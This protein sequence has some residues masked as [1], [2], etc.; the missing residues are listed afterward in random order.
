MNR[1]IDL[2]VIDDSL[3]ELARI[4]R[5]LRSVPGVMYLIRERNEA[6][7][8]LEECLSDPPD[9]VLLNVYMPE[10]NGIEFL[11][12][13]SARREVNVPVILLGGFRDEAL[14][15]QAL[16]LG[17]QDYLQKD[18]VTPESLAWSIELA[19]ERFRIGRDL[20]IHYATLQE[21]NAALRESAGRLEAIFAQSLI[22]I[23]ETDMA[24]RINLANDAFCRLTGRTREA[25]LGRSLREV[26]GCPEAPGDCT[27]AEDEKQYRRP[28]GS[29]IWV[30]ESISVLRDKRGAAGRVVMARNIT[31]RK[32]GQA[33]QALLASI[34]EASSDAVIYLDR[35]G[36]IRA[37]NRG[38]TNTYGYIAEEALGQSF[39]ILVPADRINEWRNLRRT[40]GGNRPAREFETVRLRK[41]GYRVAAAVT[42]SVVQSAT[43]EVT[44]YSAI[45][46]NISE[47]KRVE[48]KLRKSEAQYRLLA[49]AMPQ[50]VYTNNAAGEADFVNNH[51][52]E[53]TGCPS[54]EL[55][56]L[57]WLQLVHADD[58]ESMIAAW[59][60]AVASGAAFQHEY[61]LRRADGEY[62]WHLSRAHTVKN[63]QGEVTG[64]IG[65]STDINDCKL[66]EENLRAS[67]K[68][69]CRAQSPVGVTA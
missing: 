58:R 36:V 64:W 23:A 50:I 53:Y 51:A 43:G 34:V 55:L 68:S 19:R 67:E 14:A 5:Q 39:E 9:C 59:K 37:W 62:R 30:L 65:T 4:R 20:A 41:D 1:E 60:S 42:F 66:T 31:S 27:E 15:Y 46:R 22:G 35:A 10:M 11:Q 21:G 8:A 6:A 61:R 52:T 45:E 69:P 2:L 29:S 28:D 44:G 47:R 49:N 12:G 48:E 7:D 13:M 33:A 25:I 16:Q 56:R 38:A 17:A 40:A 54:D 32:S 3:E 57:G 18:E 63:G 24:G 26:T